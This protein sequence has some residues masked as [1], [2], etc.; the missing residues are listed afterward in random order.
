MRILYILF[1][2]T[3]LLFSDPVDLQGKQPPVPRC[4]ELSCDNLCHSWGITKD[5]EWIDILKIDTWVKMMSDSH[6]SHTRSCNS[7]LGSSQRDPDMEL[8]KNPDKYDEIQCR[9][10]KLIWNLPMTT[11]RAIMYSQKLYNDCAT[12]NRTLLFL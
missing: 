6:I 2:F 1:F 9:L 7:Y 3:I 10:Y 11:W 4:W 5:I 12:K 8:K